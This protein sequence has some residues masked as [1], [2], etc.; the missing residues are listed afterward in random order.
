MGCNT[1]VKAVS[2]IF[3]KKLFIVF[4]ALSLSA[5][6][7]PVSNTDVATQPEPT[8]A[9]A[10]TTLDP[11][12]DACEWL[13]NATLGGGPGEDEMFLTR[14][15][16][17]TGES[18]ISVQELVNTL[19]TDEERK[20]SEDSY[21]SMGKLNRDGS[22]LAV[23]RWWDGEEQSIVEIYDLREGKKVQGFDMPGDLLDISAD[24][25]HYLYEQTEQFYVYDA[26][27]SQILWSGPKDRDNIDE[28]TAQALNQLAKI[29]PDTSMIIFPHHQGGM[30][31]MDIKSG[32]SKR[33]L[34]DQM[35]SYMV[36]WNSLDQLVY[37]TYT[38]E[39]SY[40]GDIYL[41]D[42]MTEQSKRIG[43]ADDEF[44]LS[45]DITKMI[46]I[47]EA[48]VKVFLVDLQDGQKK[49]ISSTVKGHGNWIYP[50]Q[51]IKSNV[52]YLKYRA[53]Q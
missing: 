49:D 34:Q 8:L 12:E 20:D 52:D 51:W 25:T 41:L 24:L 32:Q 23:Y 5:C 42:T 10:K 29:S 16:D 43:T 28:T 18:Y 4:L 50:Q 19:Q 35:I 27:T 7:S 15:D 44:T 30:V 40:E 33:I 31:L 46:I 53:V 26:V 48:L 9:I 36:Q 11:K 22:R 39:E 38:D 14:L 2:M 47:N 13:L 45:P 37:K 3:I 1:S 21:L 6:T 17:S